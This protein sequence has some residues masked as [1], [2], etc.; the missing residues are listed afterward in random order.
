MNPAAPSTSNP[1][2]VQPPHGP[3]QA[4]AVSQ[5]DHVQCEF[6]TATSP[7]VAYCLQR[8][9]LTAVCVLCAAQ[10]VSGF[11]LFESSKEFQDCR[12]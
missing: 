5:T 9:Y 12:D 3:V 6:P 7:N 2:E 11:N 4:S 8:P 1:T 10:I